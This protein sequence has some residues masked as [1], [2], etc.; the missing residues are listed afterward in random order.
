[1]PSS[2]ASIEFIT[3]VLAQQFERL[4]SHLTTCEW[5]SPSSDS[6]YIYSTLQI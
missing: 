2:K 4:V 3:E 5:K 6:V 1:M